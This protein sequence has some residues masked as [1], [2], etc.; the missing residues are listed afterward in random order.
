MQTGTS[1]DLT[2]F[3]CSQKFWW[4]SVDLDKS[5]IQSC[6]SAAPQRINFEWLQQNSGELFNTPELLAE[7]AAMLNGLAVASCNNTCWAAEAQGIASR[8]LIMNTDQV[9]HRDLRSDPE[10]LNIMVGKDCN[11]TCS[12][13]CKH[14]STGWIREIQRN[15]DYAVNARDDR[16]TLNDRDRVRLYVSQKELDTP[17]RRSLIKEI[18]TLVHSGKLRGIMISGGEPFL[19]NDLPDVLSQM[20]FEVPIT[21][22]SG[23]GVDPKRFQREINTAILYQNC[24]V[25]VSAENTEAAYEFNRAGNSWSRFVTNIETLE[26]QH[27]SFS[28]NS[29]ISNLTVFGLKDFVDWAGLVPIAFSACTDPDYLGVHVMDPESKQLILQQIDELPTEAKNIIVGAIMTEPTPLQIANCR[30]YV[31]EF[32]KR[33]QL[34]L[35]IFPQSF[36]KWLHDVV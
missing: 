1:D 18:G 34:S 2:R 9:T 17:R 5:Q 31:T 8:R 7:R 13:C 3:Y 27:M 16:L 35:D 29:V 33:R 4:L 19:Y 14:Y 24:S 10:I 26:Q 11:M 6:C 20:P 25:V 22:W 28:F 30:S 23:L 15:G 21:I 36:V 12:Y 32:A